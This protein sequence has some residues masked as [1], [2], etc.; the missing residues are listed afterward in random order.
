MSLSFWV[1]RPVGLK[2]TFVCRFSIFY[3][4]LTNHIVSRAQM[5]PASST[6][7]AFFGNPGRRL[8][9]EIVITPSSPT[10]PPRKK[11]C[12]FVAAQWLHFYRYFL[13]LCCKLLV[14][15][16]LV[17]DLNHQILFHTNCCEASFS[18]PKLLVHVQLIKNKVKCKC[19]AFHFL[20]FI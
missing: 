14:H 12:L 20:I 19:R 2:R 7:F 5:L 4:K 16:Q 11:P 6:R 10:P 8:S 1:W 3:F 15:I 17:V 9:K 13:T 18:Q